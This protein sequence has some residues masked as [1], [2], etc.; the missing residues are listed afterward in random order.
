MCN[1][2]ILH[3]DHEI[4][5]NASLDIVTN[6]TM[7]QRKL[8]P[9]FILGTNPSTR[10]RKPKAGSRLILFRTG[11]RKPKA[12]SRCTPLFTPSLQDQDSRNPL[13]SLASLLNREIG[14]AEQAVGLRGRESLI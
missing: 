7:T 12:G 13:N 5:T 8:T 4:A 14:L 1:L 2:R 10:D 9:K 6:V 3:S 11:S